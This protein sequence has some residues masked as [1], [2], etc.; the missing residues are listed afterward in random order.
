MRVKRPLSSVDSK[1]A[2]AHMSPELALVDPQ[3]ATIAR[4]LLGDPGDCLAQRHNHALSPRTS[5]AVAAYPVP[6]H[7]TRAS[8]G[9]QVH[10]LHGRSRPRAHPRLWSIAGV[11]SVVTAIVMVPSLVALIPSLDSSRPEPVEPSLESA[12]RYTSPTSTRTPAPST[13]ASAAGLGAT[14][15]HTKAQITWPPAEGA[16]LYNVILLRQ[17]RR[18]DLWPERSAV[19]LGDPAASGTEQRVAPGTYSWFAYPGSRAGKRVRYGPLI[20]H[21]T[22]RVPTDEGA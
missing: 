10:R 7:P 13:K 22:V 6:R 4:A 3:L 9:P 2:M 11:V 14:P 15:P 5:C 16:S 19:T 20:A 21:G 8:A 17:G 18:I 12:R 1:R